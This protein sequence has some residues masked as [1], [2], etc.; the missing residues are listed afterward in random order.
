MHFVRSAYGLLMN[1]G[2]GAPVGLTQVL[3]VPGSVNV[4][5]T[6]F[7][8]RPLAGQNTLL[9]SSLAN[10]APALPVSLVMVRTAALCSAVVVV[11]VPLIAAVRLNLQV[12]PPTSTMNVSSPVPTSVVQLL[13]HSSHLSSPT[14][15][16]RHQ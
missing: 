10:S 8:S 5:K 11:Y 13:P 6:M 2:F 12:R 4:S 14:T 7:D 9:P 16:L 3:A 15:F 1:T